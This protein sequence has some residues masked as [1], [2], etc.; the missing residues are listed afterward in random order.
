[1]PGCTRYSAAMAYD[2][3]AHRIVVALVERD[4][5]DRLLALADPFAD[6]CG[7]AKTGRR[8]GQR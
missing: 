5:G 1:M 3:K 7:L 2:Q 8:G 4:P 6:Q